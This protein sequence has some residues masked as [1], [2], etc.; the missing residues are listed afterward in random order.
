MTTPTTSAR[1][2]AGGMLEE[3]LTAARE[4]L[5]AGHVHRHDAKEDAD[6][7][8]QVELLRR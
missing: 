7:A 8:G 2:R 4:N 6:A 5:D 3:V 1:T